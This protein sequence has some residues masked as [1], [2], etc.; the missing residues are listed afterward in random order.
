M[1][2]L[3]F[4]DP[5]ENQNMVYRQKPYDWGMNSRRETELKL[6]NKTSVCSSLNNCIEWYE[7]PQAK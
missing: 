7:P 6:H 5:L 4:W 3:F 1:I 2:S